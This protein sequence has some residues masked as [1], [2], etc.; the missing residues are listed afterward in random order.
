M[1]EVK[2]TTPKRN[3]PAQ[4]N[5]PSIREQRIDAIDGI[6]QIIGLGCIMTGQYADAGAIDMH[7][8]GISI[9]AVNLAE[10]NAGIA[11]G[12]DTLLQV[13]PYAAIVAVSMPLIVQVLVNHKVVPAEKMASANVVHPDVLE[14]Q[15]KTKM[16]HAAMEAL[17]AQRDA[18]NELA[19]MQAE[20]AAASQN[21]Q[22]EE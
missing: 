17:R 20:F 7:G 19:A 11:K 18:E 3:P 15:V 10:K 13:G 2:V 12:A 21:G 14:S 9:E 22:T 6:W 4:I 5:E 16:M 1:P 8:H